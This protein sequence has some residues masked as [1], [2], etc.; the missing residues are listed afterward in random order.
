MC[1]FI[2]AISLR[3]GNMNPSVAAA[4]PRMADAIYHRGP[5]A[6][7][8]EYFPGAALGHRRLSIID[9][10]GGQQPMCSESGRYWIIFNGEIYN[11]KIIRDKLMS[12]G[13]QFKTTCDTETIVQ[14]YEMYGSDCV[15]MLEGMF[16]FAIYD[17]ESHALFMARDRV[18]KKP[19]FYGEF[20]GHFLFGSEIK[21]FKPCPVWDGTLDWSGLEG[22][23]SL[24]YYMGEHSVYKHV[25]KLE[26]GKWMKVVNG[27]V[28]IQ[29]YWDI[30]EF[31]TDER[32]AEEIVA[33]LD[34]IMGQAVGDRLESEV[35]LGAFLSS[36]IDSS[37]I[38]SYM[39]GILGNDILTATVGFGEKDHN[40]LPGASLVSKRYGTNH[41]TKIISPNFDEVF[42]PI[43]KAFDEPF[44]D[45][46]AIP[47]YYV[48]QMAKEQVTVALSGDGGDEPFGGY[49]F[50]YVPHGVEDKFRKM[51]PGGMGRGLMRMM[52]GVWPRYRWLPRFLRLATIFE[53]MGRSAAEAYYL[54]LCFV[55]PWDA[56]K[57]MGVEGKRDPK[58][59]PV[60]GDVS[61]H[62]LGCG[63][64]DAMQRAMYADMKVYMPS[65]PLVKVDRMSML[66]SLEVRSPL[67]DRR[68]VELAYKINS[69]MKIQQGQS[70]YLLR[71]LGQ[72]RLPEELINL[73]K[74]GFSAPI[75]QWLSDSHSQ[76]FE[77]E[78]LS[79]GSEIGSLLDQ[80]FV[81]RCFD[82][83]C[84]GQINHS[85]LLW[86][87]WVLE[88]WL[89]L[90]KG[91]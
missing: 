11:H 71:Q 30:Q 59:S 81:R 15:A 67:L 42:D 2:G 85:K 75:S 25:K 36:G 38:V 88:R 58:L 50:R 26:P 28:E 46:S 27:R 16:S 78:V 91:S 83:H 22:Y 90:E 32:S 89:R 18:G 31:D 76:R 79:S 14:A 7:G 82:S 84:S 47:T 39:A 80:N 48:C 68:V 69:K 86:G 17:K 77:D 6:A 63:S 1:G 55:K 33:E 24:G 41:F 13:V 52:G 35:S 19:L 45:D 5:D 57:L 44:A 62:Y 29:S 34:E 74:K 10:S 37:L 87:V 3:A 8:Y 4:L 64:N 70:K 12:K 53:N 60:Y 72:K 61:K 43:V 73:P 23:L 66:H 40:E 65:M 21:A 54:D 49:D 51:L 20:D 9:R 56:R